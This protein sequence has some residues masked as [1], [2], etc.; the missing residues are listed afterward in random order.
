MR[1]CTNGFSQPVL[2]VG[3][4]REVH[5]SP[6]E[7]GDI[8]ALAKSLSWH[9]P[10]RIQYPRLGGVFS[11]YVMEKEQLKM[12][13]MFPETDDEQ[14]LEGMKRLYVTEVNG[15]SPDDGFLS[16]APLESVYELSSFAEYTVLVVKPEQADLIGLV[17]A[18]AKVFGVSL[19]VLSGVAGTD[20]S[21]QIDNALWDCP[22]VSYP[23]LLSELADMQQTQLVLAESQKTQFEREK[24]RY[25]RADGTVKALNIQ[26]ED[27][28]AAD[29]DDA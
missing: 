23:A 21:P 20:I 28:S 16:F 25:T 12:L 22:R 29:E 24:E 14:K 3:F 6:D 9:S 27:D 19:T 18:N 10:V 26:T 5:V 7:A 13:N 1:V 15:D 11:R 17:N 8:L 2:I 4:P